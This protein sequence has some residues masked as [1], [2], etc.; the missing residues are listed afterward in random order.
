MPADQVFEDGSAFAGHLRLRR[1]ERGQRKQAAK[2]SNS[3]RRALSKADRAVV[4]AKTGGQC[5]LCGEAIGDDDWAA[6][7]VFPKSTGGAEGLG[8]F[9]PAHGLCNGYKWDNA[10]EDFQWLLKLGVWLRHEIELGSAIGRTAAAAFVAY[11]RR[12]HAR[13]K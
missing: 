6:D 9:L 13:R 7:H 3:R 2:A 4:L 10:A 11:D 1:K 5:H 12:R 8:N